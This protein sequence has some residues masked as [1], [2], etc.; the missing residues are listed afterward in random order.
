MEVLW[1]NHMEIF[2]QGLK[3]L[4]LFQLDWGLTFLHMFDFD[5]FDVELQEQPNCMH[6]IE[7]NN[8]ERS[9]E[10]LKRKLNWL[11]IWSDSSCCYLQYE[12]GSF[13]RV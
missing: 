12:M 4:P 11:L 1:H 6:E 7:K 9:L 10:T 2:G 3:K 13:E 5:A 8:A